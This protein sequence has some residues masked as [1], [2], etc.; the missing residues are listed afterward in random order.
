MLIE[1]GYNSF[2][3]AA[4][5]EEYGPKNTGPKTLEMMKRDKNSNRRVP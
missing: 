3:A 5:K 1:E 2:D 4:G